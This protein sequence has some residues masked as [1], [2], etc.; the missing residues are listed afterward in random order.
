MIKLISRNLKDPQQRALSVKQERQD[1][2]VLS[3]I[4]TSAAGN[5]VGTLKKTKCERTEHNVF[6]C[7]KIHQEQESFI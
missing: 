1:N 2:T 6:L 7:A 5:K 3:A 4:I